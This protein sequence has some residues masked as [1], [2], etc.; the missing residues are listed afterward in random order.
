MKQKAMDLTKGT[1]LKGILLFCIPILIANIFQLCYSLADMA[2]VGHFLGKDALGAVGATE[3]VSSLIIN[4]ANGMTIGFSLITARFYGAQDEKGMKN[5]VFLTVVLTISITAVLSAV[6]VILAMPLLQVLHTP[7]DIIREAYGYMVILLAGMIMTMLYNMMASLLRAVGNSLGALLFLALAV[8]INIILDFLLVGILKMGV[9]GAA[10]A[11]V[12]SQAV[13]VAACYFYINY[14][15]P[16]LIFERK[17]MFFSKKL[18]L[19]L[20]AMGL[21]MGMMESIVNAGTLALQG[22]INGLGKSVIIAHMAARKIGNVF[23]QPLFALEGAISTFASQNYGAGKKERI[24]EGVKQSV[25]LTAVWSGA[26]AI[27]IYLA[28]AFLLESVAGLKDADIIQ[29][30]VWYLRIN[31]PFY[32]VLGIFLVVRPAMQGTGKKMVPLISSA[33][34]LFGKIFASILL[35]PIFQYTGVC[36]SEPI[37]WTLSTIFLCTVFFKEKKKMLLDQR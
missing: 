13:S 6:S 2:I 16:I 18:C 15:F 24:F 27:I 17:D 19:E 12:L 20:F 11:T 21:T 26:S 4:F 22:A 32:W 5:A 35:V 7:E 28:G 25:F 31:V 1:P 23:M 37:V 33:I 10:A 14:C 30:G 36:V 9:S 8:T 29:T 34:E 3:P